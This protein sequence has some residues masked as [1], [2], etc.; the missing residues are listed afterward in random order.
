MKSIEET[1]EYEDIQNPLYLQLIDKLIER[2]G[3]MNVNDRLPSE[4][5]LCTIYKVSRTTVRQAMYELELNGYVTKIQGSGTHVSKS[6]ETKQDLADYYSFT[7]QTKAMG[8]TPR[9]RTLEFRVENSNKSTQEKMKLA[10]GTKVIRFVR[11]RLADDIP[12]MLET[13]YLPYTEFETLKK[14]DLSAQPLYDIFENVYHKKVSRVIEQFSASNLTQKQSDI[15]DVSVNMACL[16]V[17]R[18]SYDAKGNI[19]EMTHSLVR[20][21]QYVYQTQIKVGE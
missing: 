7:K 9:T 8:K 1:H 21:D 12:M 6:N 16:K 5:D 19:I 2:I 11:L 14:R 10:E 18:F 20:P 17:T 3:G 15:M 4:R 13:T